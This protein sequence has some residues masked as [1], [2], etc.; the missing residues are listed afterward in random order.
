M[1]KTTED[2][3]RPNRTGKMVTEKQWE[4][5]TGVSE[6]HKSS[7]DH[8]RTRGKTLKGRLRKSTQDHKRN[9]KDQNGPKRPLKTTDDYQDPTGNT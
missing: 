5:P 9:I 1:A 6:S 3:R 2:R 8:I 4:P 7:K